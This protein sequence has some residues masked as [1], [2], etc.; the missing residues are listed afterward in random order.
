MK[1]KLCGQTREEDIAFSLESGADLCGVVIEVPSSKRSMQFEDAAPLFRKFP[2]KI[3]ALTANAD[4]TLYARIA[5]LEPAALQL[6]ADAAPEQV[7]GLIK[8]Y[9]FV[10]W[11]S[12]HLPLPAEHGEPVE[13]FLERIKEYAEA[14][15]GTVVLDS[16]TPDCYG[17]SGVRCDWDLAGKII[18][19]SRADIF[20]AGG[21]N[22]ENITEAAALN[23]YG[24]DLASGVEVSPGIKSRDKIRALFAALAGKAE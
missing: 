14:G 17:G 2:G 21:I 9:G 10:I 1:I 4:D 12:L 20:L 7:A 15:C 5:G 19:E 24:I 22:P 8:K 13:T 16:C 3:A 18:A 6:T 11:K 23:P